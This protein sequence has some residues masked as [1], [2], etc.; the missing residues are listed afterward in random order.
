MVMK[1]QVRIL[2][3]WL[4]ASLLSGGL[5]GCGVTSEVTTTH[6]SASSVGIAQPI[7]P[8]SAA[9]SAV[10]EGRPRR[11]P[12]GSLP[13]AGELPSAAVVAPSSATA[14]SSASTRS[15]GEVAPAP[16]PTPVPSASAAFSRDMRTQSGRIIDEAGEP[17]V[18]ATVLLKGTT[19]GASTDA[20]GNYSLTVPLG[21]NIFVFGYS[22]Y[23]DE[24]AQSRDGQPITVTLLP[25]PAAEVAKDPKPR[26]RRK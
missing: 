14:A 23:Q 6:P 5:A 25:A 8:S 7:A 9:Y 1:Y 26:S 12:D 13:A 15:A 22:G 21:T 2:S 20:N 3:H 19:R 18:G 16:S 4:L 10:G 24:V 17:L 11:L